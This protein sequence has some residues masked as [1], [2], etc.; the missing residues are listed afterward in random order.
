MKS[1][2]L[3]ERRGENLEISKILKESWRLLLAH[4][5]LWILLALIVNVI[6]LIEIQ[7]IFNAVVQ[8]IDDQLDINIRQIIS[9]KLTSLSNESIGIDSSYLIEISSYIVN[10]ILLQ[11]MVAKI[12]FSM[13][14]D[15]KQ[16]TLRYVV[17]SLQGNLLIN[18]LRTFGILFFSVFYF[19]ITIGLIVIFDGFFIGLL[20]MFLLMVAGVYLASRLSLALPAMVNENIGIFSSYSSSWKLTSSCRL[21]ILLLMLVLSLL[22]GIF[23]FGILSYYYP[24][25][26]ESELTTIDRILVYFYEMIKNL[27]TA[28]ILSVCY[29]YLRT[30][31]SA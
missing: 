31:G 26:T 27:A 1:K 3:S 25:S 7:H 15:R 16:L 24:T 28:M 2:S 29:H 19:V 4:P 18:M 20:L 13:L 17:S 30:A 9:E 10:V 14:S 21:K 12:V 6:S 22:V 23:D 11:L 5:F 8:H